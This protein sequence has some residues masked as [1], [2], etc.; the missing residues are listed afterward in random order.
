MRNLTFSPKIVLGIY[1]RGLVI[2]SAIVVD[3]LDEVEVEEVDVLV[4]LVLVEVLDVEV[5]NE[6]LVEVL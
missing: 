3:V 1:T 5:L 2:I 6:V 4:L